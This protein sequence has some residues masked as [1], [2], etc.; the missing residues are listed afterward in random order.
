MKEYP[1][2]NEELLKM[3]KKGCFDKISAKRLLKGIDI[4]KPFRTE[5]GVSTTYL[6]EAAVKE[7]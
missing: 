5:S 1:Q 3:L 7:S 2:G 6:Y 4:N